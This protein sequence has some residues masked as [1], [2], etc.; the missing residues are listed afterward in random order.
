MIFLVFRCCADSAA[1]RLNEE[2]E[3][4]AWVRP[5]ALASYDLNEPTVDTLN[6]AGL[7]G[8]STAAPTPAR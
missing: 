8:G 3:S 6:R 5:D 1:V 2:F 7:L 4:Y